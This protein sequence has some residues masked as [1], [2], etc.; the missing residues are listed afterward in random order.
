MSTGLG[1]VYHFTM[2]WPGHTARDLRTLLDWEVARALRQVPGVVEVNGWGGDSREIEVRLRTADLRAL[3]VGQSDV[4]AALL[5]AGHNAGGGALERDEE[6]V[7]VRLDGQ[8]RSAAEVADQVVAVRPG[9]LPILVRDVA[10]V[11]DGAAPGSPPRPPTAR[12]RPSTR[13][14][15]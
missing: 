5:G 4:E 7:L 12:A 9:G 6:L 15:R 10:T 13:W 14:C 11:R 3:G 1:E 2:R 8:L